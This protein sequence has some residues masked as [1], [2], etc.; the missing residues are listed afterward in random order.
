MADRRWVSLK[1]LCG[2]AAVQSSVSLIRPRG[3]I[4]GR[5]DLSQGFAE[6][7]A[8]TRQTLFLLCTMEEGVAFGL[9]VSVRLGDDTTE[10]PCADAVWRRVVQTG[11]V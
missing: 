8:G 6:S 10:V 3:R 5:R 11:R 4:K 9:F 1:G 2:K 7:F